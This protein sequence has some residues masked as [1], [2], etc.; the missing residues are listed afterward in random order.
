MLIKRQRG[1]EIPERLA[2]P[3]AVV[4][5]RRGII[6]GALAMGAASPAAAA[7]PGRPWGGSCTAAARSS[8][9]TGTST[10]GGGGWG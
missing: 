9:P 7:T 1:W 6:A 3:E 8:A 2:T 4:L 10:R 5:G